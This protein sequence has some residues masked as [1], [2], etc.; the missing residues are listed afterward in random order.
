MLRFQ[1]SSLAW[2]ECIVIQFC[3]CTLVGLGLEISSCLS[4]VQM[5]DK[6]LEQ[7][8]EERSKLEIEMCELEADLSAAHRDMKGIVGGDLQIGHA[9]TEIDGLRKQI[10]QSQEDRT[11]MLSQVH[12]LPVLHVVN[13]LWSLLRQ[14]SC[15]QLL[16]M[17]SLTSSVGR[18]HMP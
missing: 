17:H 12:C 13:G 2:Q 15:A 6:Q 18:W 14:G 16:H 9:L 7:A 10:V 1:T 4:V 3:S 11:Q 8:A 5:R